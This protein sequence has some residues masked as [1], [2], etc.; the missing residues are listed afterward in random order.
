MVTRNGWATA[1][2]V[3]AAAILLNCNIHVILEGQNV[4][5]SQT[6]SSNDTFSE[7]ELLLARN[8]YRVLRKYLIEQN[9][10][11]LA[12]D[13]YHTKQTQK[14]KKPGF[15]N[16]K[17]YTATLINNENEKHTQT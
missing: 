17:S 11:L 9:R 2:E 10:P 15:E 6:Y 4:Y 3:E 1:A 5:I 12:L 16:P 13:N 7:I 14:H 8:H